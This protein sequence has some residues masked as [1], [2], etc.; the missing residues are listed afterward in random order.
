[1]SRLSWSNP[2][3]RSTVYQALA[4][5]AVAGLAWFLVSNTLANL[6]A[7]NISSGFGFLGREAGFAIGEAPI[8]YDPQDT[9]ARAILVGLLNTLRVAAAGI[10]LA[11]ILGTVVG[12][13]RL[14]RN[15]LVA[16]LASVYVEL[17]RNTPLLLQ[18]F[19]WYALVTETL[20]PARQALELL[21][22]VFLSNR[23]IKLPLPAD[24][25][26]FDLAAAGFGLAVALSLALAHWMRRRQQHSGDVRPIAHWVVALLVGLPL[27]GWLAGGAPMQFDVPHLQGFGFTG[28]ATLTP[29]FTAL[30]F[31]LVIYTAAFIAEVVRAGIQSVNRGQWEA[32]ESLGLRRSKVL[33]LVVL[34]QAL[35]VIIPPVTSQYLNLT[36]NS[37]LA[38]AIGYPDIVSIA[39][40]TLN[41]TGQAIE[42]VLIIMAV[43]LAVSLTISVLMNLYNRRMALVER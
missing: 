16:R 10:V 38:V 32:A 25:L 5:A 33:R 40:T 20:P 37:S 43:Y 17:M 18:L 8:R 1:M 30:L 34:P 31:G 3:V 9:Y 42:G 14:S 11:T 13:A 4:L 24:H 23:G 19:L 27:A 21:P 36:K 35:R 2:S 29:E 26:G 15:W 28:G 39:N 22:G 41:Q 7:R 6:A 12:I